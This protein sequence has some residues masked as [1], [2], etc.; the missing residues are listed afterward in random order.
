[1]Y[2]KKCPSSKRWWDSNPRP[3]GHES[4]PIITRPGLPPSVFYSSF[5][6]LF[7]CRICHLLMLYRF[8]DNHL[9]EYYLI[10]L[11]LKYT[12]LYANS[13]ISLKVSRSLLSY[14]DLFWAISISFELFRSSFVFTLAGILWNHGALS[15]RRWATGSAQQSN[16]SGIMCWI[17]FLGLT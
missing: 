9:Q 13:S 7:V 8:N 10:H 3:S 17:I 6:L 1:M 16:N 2:V 5:T 4:P 11:H 12:S 14:F 15:R